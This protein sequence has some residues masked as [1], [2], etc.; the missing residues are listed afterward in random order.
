MK[1]ILS[2]FL[3]LVLALSLFACGG[4]GGDGDVEKCDVCVDGDNSGTCDVCGEAMPEEP[5]SDIA[6]IED[7][8]A[9][10]SIVYSENANSDVRKAITQNIVSKLKNSHKIEV[11][12]V[13]EGSQNDVPQDIEILIGDVTSRGAKY[14]IDRY[15]LGKEGYTF[16][17]V[18]SK[19]LINAGS[20]EQLVEAIGE[21]AEDILKIGSDDV[22][23]ATMLTTDVVYKVQDDYK[24]KSVTVG[25][26]DM[27]GYT[28]ATDIENAQ[29][30]AAALEIQDAFYDKTGYY[31]KIVDT[32]AATDKSIVIKHI[33]KVSG[34]DSF[35]VKVEDKQLVISCA[36]DNMLEQAVGEFLVRNI[37][38]T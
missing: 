30:M 8:I 9:N 26:T 36:Y 35:T 20:D 21:F 16:K 28:I 23:Y 10:F 5:I 25:G 33:D 22:Y 2:L 3:F 18:G 14:T 11:S 24:I 13:M 7:G 38:L 17:I 6:L 31:F 4:G 12:A 27:K 34:T 37:T 1:K 29:Y 15:A 32:D 19:I